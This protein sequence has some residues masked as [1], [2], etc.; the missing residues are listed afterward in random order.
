MSDNVR[1]GLVVGGVAAVLLALLWRFLVVNG[2][3]RRI[4][5]R[6]RADDPQER[7]RAGILLVDE[8]LQRSARVLLS[9]VATEPDP[10]ASHAIA[11]AVAR[12]QWEPVDSLRVRQLREWAAQELE[13]HG[14]AVAAFGPAVT[15]LSDMGGPRSPDEK[16]ASAAPGSVVPDPAEAPPAAAP[17]EPSAP[18]P[19]A[20]DPNAPDPNAEVHWR[21]DQP[22]AG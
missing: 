9:H 20:P 4:R 21:A 2:R 8:G 11:L 19:N 7:A 13:R 1:I 3:R 18:D 5:K 22:G 10:R 14:E 12:R 16:P 15:R 17:A 6:L